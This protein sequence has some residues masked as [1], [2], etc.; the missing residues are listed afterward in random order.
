MNPYKMDQKKRKKMNGLQG[1]Q[2]LYVLF[3]QLFYKSITLL[4]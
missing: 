4:I 1:L 3:L 2:E